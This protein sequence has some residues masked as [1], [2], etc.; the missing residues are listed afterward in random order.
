[1]PSLNRVQLLGNLGRD[2]ELRYTADGAA[3]ATLSLATSHAW[4]D[5]DGERHEETEWTRVVLFG[6]QAE[7][8]GDHLRKGSQ[9]LVEGRLRTRRWQDKETGQ[10]RYTTEVVADN[11]L[12]L[13]SRPDSKTEAQE[14]GSED[15]SP[16]G[17]DVAF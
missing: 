9:C 11:L 8:A 14:A 2:P 6:R 5:K 3:I 7:V 13:G 15:A 16:S 4:K 17:D 1:M 12:L 10:D